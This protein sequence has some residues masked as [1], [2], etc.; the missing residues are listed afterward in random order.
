M[1][2]RDGKPF[3]L[4]TFQLFN[5]AEG[6]PPL[7]NLLAPRQPARFPMIGKKFSNGWKKLVGF[8]NDL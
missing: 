3:N 1:N 2:F 8:S 4:S 5:R 6:V 7:H